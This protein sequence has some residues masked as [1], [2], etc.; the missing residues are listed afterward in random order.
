MS[1]ILNVLN[2]IYL[3]VFVHVHVCG[4]LC[5]TSHMWRSEASLFKSVLLPMR[6]LGIEL[7]LVGL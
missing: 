6:V 5:A 4:H 3:S 7:R 1:I 2:Y